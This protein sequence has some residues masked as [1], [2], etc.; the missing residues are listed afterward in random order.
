MSVLRSGAAGRTWTICPMRI[1]WRAFT[2]TVLAAVWCATKTYRINRAVAGI[3]ARGAEGL[4]QH[5]LSAR[6]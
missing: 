2:L 4:L 1:A 6:G 5:D 3:Q